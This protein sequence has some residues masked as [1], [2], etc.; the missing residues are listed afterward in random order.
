M[1]PFSS[2]TAGE[3]EGMRD[4]TVSPAAL[5]AGEAIGLGGDVEKRLRRM[6]ARAAP[7]T[8]PRGNRRFHDFVLVIEQGVVQSVARLNLEA[9]HP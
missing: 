6:A 1:R 3:G 2:G 7:F 5:Q 8:H 4:F 9:N